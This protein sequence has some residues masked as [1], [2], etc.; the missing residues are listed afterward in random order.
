[1]SVLRLVKNIP[2]LREPENKV[3]TASVSWSPSPRWTSITR[4]KAVAKMVSIVNCPYT[5]CGNAWHGFLSGGGG[6]C[7]PLN[8]YPP[9]P[10]DFKLQFMKYTVQYMFCAYSNQQYVS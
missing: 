7:A 10:G 3:F 4:P 9:T 6:I 1:M 8:T 5:L 2:P